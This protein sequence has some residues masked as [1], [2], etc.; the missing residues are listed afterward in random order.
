MGFVRSG[1]VLFGVRVRW[2]G[3]RSATLVW[4]GRSASGQR[5]PARPSLPRGPLLGRAPPAARLRRKQT[6]HRGLQARPRVSGVS[7]DPY[8]PQ[9]SDNSARPR[10]SRDVGWAR[11][12][13]WCISD[14][15]MTRPKSSDRRP[16]SGIF[17]SHFF[18]V[19]SRSEPVPMSLGS[20]GAPYL[21]RRQGA[22]QNS[23]P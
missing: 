15:Y 19:F 2:L 18:L 14:R 22:F 5:Y 13:V 8:S 9:Q 21:T 23:G 6:T 4:G 1:S 20:A 12:G 7:V 17:F 3:V 11:G 10:G 16:E